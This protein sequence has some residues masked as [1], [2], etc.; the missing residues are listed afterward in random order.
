MML[1]DTTGMAFA[2][3]V[4]EL[5]RAFRGQWPGMELTLDFHNTRGIGLA[6]VLPGIGAG[7]KRFDASLGGIGG[8]PYARGASG[9]FS[10]EEIAHALVLID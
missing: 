7:A 4:V 6:N 3:Q 10:A 5:T 1:W 2:T 8:C 9:N